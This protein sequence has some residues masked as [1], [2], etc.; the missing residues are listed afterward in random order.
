MTTNKTE[1]DNDGAEIVV[2][3]TCGGQMREDRFKIHRKATSHISRISKQ[4]L[5]LLQKKYGKI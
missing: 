5:I 1:Q 4:Y 3:L 2:C